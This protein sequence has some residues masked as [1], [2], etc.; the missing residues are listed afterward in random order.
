MP[1]VKRLCTQEG[2]QSQQNPCWC[3]ACRQVTR[4]QR[5]PGPSLSPSQP[6]SW[7]PGALSEIAVAPQQEPAASAPVK[8]KQGPRTCGPNP[9]V[10]TGGQ[11][12][13]NKCA[14]HE[15]HT[16]SLPAAPGCLVSSQPQAA[17]RPP[18]GCVRQPDP[19]PLP[20]RGA[21][22]PRATHTG[23]RAMAP[24][25]RRSR[26]AAQCLRERDTPPPEP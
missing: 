25:R 1:D 3:D 4:S 17:P 16:R 22:P 5:R 11:P 19:S 14:H 26:C 24:W 12:Q 8:Q 15:A 20:F 10:N 23:S 9:M 21:P 2:F 18:Q 13:K 6:P 7:A